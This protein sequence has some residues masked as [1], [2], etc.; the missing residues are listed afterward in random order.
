MMVAPYSATLFLMF[1]LDC[2]KV[3]D[4]SPPMHVQREK[5]KR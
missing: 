2:S 4:R 5:D 1:H 3:I